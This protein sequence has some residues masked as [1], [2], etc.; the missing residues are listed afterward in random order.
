MSSFAK[1]IECLKHLPGC[2]LL[3]FICLVKNSAPGETNLKII[4][5]VKFRPMFLLLL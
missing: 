2:F 4:H 1:I 3:C 5:E